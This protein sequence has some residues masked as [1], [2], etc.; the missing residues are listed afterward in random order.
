M[1]TTAQF[2]R[3]AFALLLIVTGAAKLADLPGFV[4]VVASHQT[5]PA[6]LVAPAAWALTGIE[7]LMALWLVLGRELRLAALALIA[8]HLGYLVWLLQ[9]L[10][11]GI[12]VENCGCFGVY[13][14]RPLT[15]MTLVEDG[16]LIL[17]AFGFWFTLRRSSHA[18]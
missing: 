2:L 12:A 7:F 6:I 17:L 5:L 18:D 4:G 11:R 16:V 8:L 13:W 1:S 15:P 9:L 14:P 10:A 3:W